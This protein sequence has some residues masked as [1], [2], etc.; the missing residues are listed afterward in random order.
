MVI[1]KTDKFR[2]IKELKAGKISLIT[3]KQR[4]LDNWRQESH[5]RKFTISV[6]AENKR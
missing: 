2:Q 1:E 3:K 5:K 6:T 4:K